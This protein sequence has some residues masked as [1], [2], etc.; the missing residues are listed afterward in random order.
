MKQTADQSTW[1]HSSALINTCQRG[2]MQLRR[3]RLSVCETARFGRVRSGEGEGDDRA[4][5]L[6]HDGVPS[7]TRALEHRDF[8]CSRLTLT[9]IPPRPCT[10][11]VACISPFDAYTKSES[12][13]PRNTAALPT[14]FACARPECASL[15]RRA[16]NHIV[17]LC[18]TRLVIPSPPS[19]RLLSPIPLH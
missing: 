9:P 3:G 12:N 19:H 1:L 8:P 10:S 16:S 7:L 14:T 15:G 2:W 5:A 13:N 11:P 18:V 4:G 6:G 17:R